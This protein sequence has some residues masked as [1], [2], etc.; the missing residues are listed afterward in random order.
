M[1]FPLKYLKPSF[2][3]CLVPPG[4]CSK[5]WHDLWKTAR[6]RP[7]ATP[8]WKPRWCAPLAPRCSSGTTHLIRFALSEH[9]FLRLRSKQKQFFLLSSSYRSQQQLLFIMASQGESEKL[10]SGKSTGQKGSHLPAPL[11]PSEETVVKDEAG[12]LHQSAGQLGAESQEEGEQGPRLPKEP[13]VGSPPPPTWRLR[14]FFW[15]LLTGVGAAA[16][17]V[18]GSREQPVINS[19]APPAQLLPPTR[20]GGEHIGEG[21]SQPSQLSALPEDIKLDSDG[22]NKLP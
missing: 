14:N 4:K 12:F 11:L 20:A 6:S 9:L 15:K 13:C 19:S 21:V 17:I 1:S 22:L 8:T 16:S 3:R 2:C 5:G 18:L 10:G 7:P